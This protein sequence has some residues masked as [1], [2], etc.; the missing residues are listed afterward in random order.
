[1]QV[2]FRDSTVRASNHFFGIRN[3]P[4]KPWK[5]SPCC[6]GI[7]EHN[8]VMR[9]IFTFRCASVGS[10]SISTNG[11]RKILS[12]FCCRS[13]PKSIQKAFN[14]LC[15]SIFNYL[16]M[17]KS[18]LL[19]PFTI[20]I[21][22]Q[23]TK[24][25]TFSF[26]TTSSLRTLWPE[27]RFVPLDQTGKAISGIPI[28]HCFTDF[29]THQP[30]CSVL[31]DIKKSLHLSYRHTNFVHC[32]VVQHPIPLYQRCSGSKENPTS[33]HAGSTSTILGIKQLP[34]SILLP[35]TLSQ[36]TRKFLVRCG[37]PHPMRLSDVFG[38]SSFFRYWVAGLARVRKIPGFFVATPGT[39]K[40]MWPSLLC[41]MLYTRI[42]ICKLLLKFFQAGFFVSLGHSICRPREY[43]KSN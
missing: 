15:R 42:V 37:D 23:R 8:S 32:H 7:S 40:S 34:V 36:K 18:R 13:V 43:A 17:D 11:L 31:F 3:H 12:L 1:L 16:H 6:F 14:A 41:E 30:C 24:N 20:S 29:M 38:D 26:A 39:S 35:I 27:E 2:F 21:K 28:G 19:F 4:V 25:C 9:H 10:P 22:R 33:N 5:Q